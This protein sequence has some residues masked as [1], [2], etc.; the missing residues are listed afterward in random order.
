MTGHGIF[1]LGASAGGVEALAELVEGLPPDFP[2]SLFIV[3]HFPAYASS[4]LPNI[5]SR[6]GPLRAVHPADGEEIRPGVI[7]VAPPDHHLLVKPGQV[8]LARGP[9]ENGHRPAIDPLFRTAARAYGPRVVGVV[10]TGN[11]DDGT[12][13]LSAVHRM[14]GVAVVQAPDDAQHPGMPSSALANVPVDHVLP[15]RGIAP[16][17]VRL[18]GEAVAGGEEGTVPDELEI[19]AD[20][21]ELDPL[22][23]QGD[24]RPGDPAGF[25]CPECHGPLWEIREGEL[26]RYRCRVGHAYGAE[27][28]L[29][30]QGGAVESALWTAL[31]ALKQ[32]AALA[33]QMAHRMERRGNRHSMDRF[34]DQAREADHRAEVIRKVLATGRAYGEAGYETAE[35]PP[36]ATTAA[37]G[38]SP[39]SLRASGM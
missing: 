3:V 14:G 39:P 23:L 18:A 13:G 21:A 15:L 12:A 9:R 7:Y 37:E 38:A 6:R 32:R 20:I 30:E 28:L 5:L 34:E 4:S 26:V 2:G 29:A 27:T 35:S 24:D 1:V 11:L 31:Q 10:L 33:R 16:L 8:R 36:G 19:E 25:T 22:A 17:L